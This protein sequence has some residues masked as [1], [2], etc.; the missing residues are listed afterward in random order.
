M[1]WP[2]HLAFRAAREYHH[3]TS[4]FSRHSITYQIGISLSDIRSI[5]HYV[6]MYN[7]YCTLYFDSDWPSS[8]ALRK[9]LHPTQWFIG[10][11]AADP[12]IIS[13]WFSR[14]YQAVTW[15]HPH[16]ASQNA[17]WKKIALVNRYGGL[18]GRR[19]NPTWT[20]TNQQGTKAVRES[21]GLDDTY[22]GSETVQ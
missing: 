4:F 6:P 7:N 10:I 11:L 3:M 8:N 21:A 20:L 14:L 18:A 13:Q 1:L 19:W 15:P 5:P 16:Y 22:L 12:T 9:L 2:E 17:N